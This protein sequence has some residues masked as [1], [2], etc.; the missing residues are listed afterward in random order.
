MWFTDYYTESEKQKVVW[1]Q[2]GE[3]GVSAV[4]T[5]DLGGDQELLP[6]P[7]IT[8]ASQAQGKI[9]IQ[10]SKSFEWRGQKEENMLD[11]S[12]YRKQ[13]KKKGLN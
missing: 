4:S 12:T 6:L 10:N 3:V 5:C 1:A 8:G 9:K 7:R 11:D 13:K 2:N